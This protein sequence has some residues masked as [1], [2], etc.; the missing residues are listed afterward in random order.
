M[1]K[2]WNHH[3]MEVLPDGKLVYL[4]EFLYFKT[5]WLAGESGRAE[6]LE[7]LYFNILKRYPIFNIK[8][9]L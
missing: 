7:I 3:K 9:S 6:D 5:W 1:H 4:M 2:N 8:P